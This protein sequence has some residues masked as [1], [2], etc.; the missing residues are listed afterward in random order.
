MAVH[1]SAE[2]Y[3]ETILLLSKKSDAVH[4]IDIA[5]ELGFSKASVSVAMKKLRDGEYIT[6]DA[7]GS[8]ALT[9]KGAE[10]A[11]QI[12]ERHATFY[13]WFIRLGVSESIAAADAC[14]I[15]HILHEETF[16]AI[17][18]HITSSLKQE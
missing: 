18:S 7:N 9:G 12:Y 6:V 15:E 13:D 8:I 2:N 5:K 16:T 14:R 1:E 4:S 11:E 17:K 10:A 3:L